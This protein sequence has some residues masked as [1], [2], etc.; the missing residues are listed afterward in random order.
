[1]HIQSRQH[2]PRTEETAPAAVLAAPA[3]VIV[4]ARVVF[5]ILAEI[6]LNTQQRPIRDN[7]DLLGIK[8]RWV[9]GDSIKM[10]NFV[11]KIMNF[12]LKIM[13]FVLEMTDFC[14]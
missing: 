13:D 6:P 1:M 9:V 4:I 5:A 14:I 11:S 10:M 8:L 3:A 7:I 12:V 2:H